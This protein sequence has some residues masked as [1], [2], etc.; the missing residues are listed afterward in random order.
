MLSYFRKNGIEYAKTQGKSV[1]VNGKVKKQNQKHIGRV[2]DKE[3]HVFYSRDKGVFTYDENTDT[4]GKADDSYSS[5]LKTDK[6]RREKLLLDFGDI[7][8]LDQLIKQIGYDKVLEAVGYG[9]PDTLKAMAMYYIVS[10]SSNVHAQ[11]WFDGS[12][13][14]LLYPNANMKSQ[15]ISDFLASIGDERKQQNYFK[16]HINWVKTHIC[17]DPAIIVD[18]TGL[19][20]DID[21]YLKNWS[22]HN[23]EISRETRMT[24]AVQRDSGYPLLYRLHPGNIVDSSTLQRTVTTLSMYDV[25]TDLAL[26]DAGYC[27]VP[28]IDELYEHEIEFVTRFPERMS[29]LYQEII[30]QCLPTLEQEENMVEYQGRFMYVKQ[31]EVEIGSGKNQ[32]YAYLCL[33]LSRKSDELHKASEKFGKKKKSTHEMHDIYTNAGL[34]IILSSLPFKSEDI[35]EVYYIRQ[36]VEQYFDI[37]KGISRLTPLRGHS[38]ETIY[39]HLMLCQIAATINLYIQKN[40]NQYKDDREELLMSLRNQKCTVFETKVI[41]SEP[42]SKANAFYDAFQINCPT[43]FK[44]KNESLIPENGIAQEGSNQM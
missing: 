19:P 14:R 2:I 13:A 20:N 21:T 17:D 12:I 39:G 40:M 28:I 23:G 30:N 33:D 38:E 9:N 1:R 34:F 31:T 6:R 4:Y 44:R 27:T 10:S 18:S 7:Y 36:L 11:T 22:N 5:V 29:S 42:Q 26:L 32:A 24:E 41:T 37:A 3:H 25:N 43:S 8:F 15:R 16:A 35:L